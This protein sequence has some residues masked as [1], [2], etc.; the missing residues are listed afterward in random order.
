VQ[1]EGLSQ[2]KNAMIS[3]GIES[4]TLPSAYEYWKNVENEIW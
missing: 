1:L 2:V 4:V 3:S